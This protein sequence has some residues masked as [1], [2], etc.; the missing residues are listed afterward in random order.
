LFAGQIVQRRDAYQLPTTLVT[1]PEAG[2][3]VRLPSEPETPT[4]GMTLARGGT[5]DADAQLGGAV[6]EQFVDLLHLD[7]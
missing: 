7:N 5:A 3:R 1:H 2:H 6:W 4:A